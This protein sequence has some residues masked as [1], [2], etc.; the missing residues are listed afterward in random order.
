[1]IS[2][3]LILLDISSLNDTFKS[4]LQLLEKLIH[5]IFNGDGGALEED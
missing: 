5:E 2:T 3:R 1:M 4:Y